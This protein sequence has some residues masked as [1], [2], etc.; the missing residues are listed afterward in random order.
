MNIDNKDNNINSNPHVGELLPGYLDGSLPAA[1]VAA[2]RAHLDT[3]DAFR[4]DY[5]DLQAT[6]AMLQQM[7]VVLTPRS[8]VITE[9][10]AARVRKPSLL[11]RIFTPRFAPTFAG[12]SV[13]AFV[14]L[15]FLFATSTTSTYV[16][17]PQVTSGLFA[18]VTESSTPSDASRIA[19]NSDAQPKQ[20][21]PGAVA[22]TAA[23][24]QPTM[25][26]MGAAPNN[27]APSLATPDP[28]AITSAP[29]PE[30]TPTGDTSGTGYSFAP[31]AQSPESA[32]TASDLANEPGMTTY[33]GNYT[34]TPPVSGNSILELGLLALGLAL[35]AAAIIA[36]RRI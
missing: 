14:L 9:E 1:D 36:R 11:E 21:G 32:T 12:G 25:S 33:S 7:P 6:R 16:S 10:T 5:A 15:V 8:F 20:S 23:S 19:Q 31:S 17:A 27:A 26:A 22:T 35:A 28:L 13:V 30:G 4:A 2:V 34:T 24:E 18:Q 29:L 3:C